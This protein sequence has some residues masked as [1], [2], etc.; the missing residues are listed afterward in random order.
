MLAGD[1]LEAPSGPSTAARPLSRS[2][3]SSRS[4]LRRVRDPALEGVEGRQRV[5][6]QREEDVDA[7]PA[8][9]EQRGE[10][11][12]ERAVDIV[13]EEVLLELVEDQ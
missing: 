10:L 1:L 9:G 3:W 7:E 6:A 8:V 4:E 11:L 5:L 13:V 2:R 12:A